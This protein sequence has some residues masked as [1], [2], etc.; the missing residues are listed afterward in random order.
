VDEQP[1]ERQ[2]V[3]FGPFEWDPARAELC[4]HGVRL[5]LA[6]QPLEVLTILLANADRLVTRE[7]LRRKL[8]GA[9]TFVDFE[10]GL[11][12][13]IA[14]LRHVLADSA[15]H[16]HYI[17]TVPGRGYRF[18]AHVVA[19]RR[20]DGV[21]SESRATR[22]GIDRRTWLAASAGLAL[23]AA[24]V[25]LGL[26][27]SPDRRAPGT[28]RRFVVSGAPGPE[29]FSSTA[30]QDIA[31]SPDGRR[32]AYRA[33]VDGVARLYV[34][35]LN[36][37]EGLFLAEPDVYS[38]FF[39]PD[40]AEVGY[41]QFTSRALLRSS[42]QGGPALRIT[43]F[44]GFLAGA[45]WGE[46]GSIVFGTMDFR[47]GLMRVSAAGGQIEPLTQAPAGFNHALPEWLPD[48]RGV[49]FTVV[50]ENR[51]ASEIAV[52]DAR[53]GRHVTLTPGSH[54]RYAVTGHLLYVL[55]DDLMAAP[56]DA[57]RLRLSGAPLC[58]CAWPP[59][60][61]RP[62]GAHGA[63]QPRARRLASGRH[64]R[65]RRGTPARLGGPQRQRAGLSSRA[66]RLHLSARFT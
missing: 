46:D 21:A 36:R 4:K 31:I 14:R 48:G 40:G 17:E 32:I 61:E 9:R 22:A 42:V 23:G 58:G 64:A 51:A 6:G 50:P 47:Q 44:P 33:G 63:V 15:E 39:S 19:A 25:Y 8:W 20:A 59:D 29:L 2:T 12:T 24:G 11:N 26:P 56:F 52:L 27:R 65:A 18:V 53:T 38:P 60:F 16:P 10:Q 28:P 43:E 1:S 3:A 57:T 37:S 41:Y 49:L 66:A 30:F 13:A 34:R 54:P 35:E 5:K 62:N 7:E 45:S 55:E